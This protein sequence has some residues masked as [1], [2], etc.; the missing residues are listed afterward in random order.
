MNGLL[1]IFQIVIFF[2][3]MSLRHHPLLGFQPPPSK[4]FIAFPV[5]NVKNFSHI[6]NYRFNVVAIFLVYAW[7]V[8]LLNSGALVTR[9]NLLKVSNFHGTSLEHHSY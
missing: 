3:Y 1:T 4:I 7:L 2:K 9:H 8:G 6:A 5:S